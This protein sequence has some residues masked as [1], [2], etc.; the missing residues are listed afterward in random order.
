M[1]G[2]PKLGRRDP[3]PTILVYDQGEDFK[4]SQLFLKDLKTKKFTRFMYFLN[5]D[6][7][8]FS[9]VV[10][11]NDGKQVNLTQEKCNDIEKNF[12]TDEIVMGVVKICGDYFS[13]SKQTENSSEKVDNKSSA[14]SPR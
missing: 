12:I 7:E 5:K 14:A 3:G 2:T 6:C 13:K 9:E 1:S 11:N 8:S 10:Y 4:V